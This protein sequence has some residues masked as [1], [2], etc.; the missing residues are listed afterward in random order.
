M[1]QKNS[2][3]SYQEKMLQRCKKTRNLFCTT[4]NNRFLFWYHII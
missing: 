4:N 3:N 2:H 1:D